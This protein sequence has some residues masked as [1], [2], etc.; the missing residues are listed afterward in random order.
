MYRK[1][2][3]AAH[4]RSQPQA[5]SWAYTKKGDLQVDFHEILKG[6]GDSNYHKST[7]MTTRNRRRCE[8]DC[9]IES[10]N[11]SSSDQQKSKDES[12]RKRSRDQFR[13]FAT[14][15]VCAS[16]RSPSRTI[17]PRPETSQVSQLRTIV[18]REQ[19]SDSCATSAR[20][21]RLFR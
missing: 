12:S 7:D 18:S 10:R 11:I 14:F 2:K 8:D 15:L 13:S 6:I 20:L 4:C 5:A 3:F 1:N 19:R 21:P 17:I 16:R 9:Q